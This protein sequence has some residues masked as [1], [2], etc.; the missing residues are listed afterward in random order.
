M[1]ISIRPIT[2]DEVPGFRTVISQA[3]GGDATEGGDERFLQQVDLGRTYVA[4]DGD[5]MV[6]TSAA[7]TF[8][9]TVPG[10]MA[11]MGGLTMVAVRPTHRRQGVLRRLMDAHFADVAARDEP[12]SGLWASETAIYGR[13]GY[14]DAVPRHH[15]TIDVK[16]TALDSALATDGVRLIG[17]DE[18]RSTLPGL[19]ETYRLGRVGALSRSDDWWSARRF[20]DGPEYREG[21]SKRRYAIAE[22]DGAPVGYVMYRQKEKWDDGWLPDGEV[23]VIEIIGD[24]RATASLW[25]FLASIDLFPRLD[26]WNAPVDDPVK[27]AASNRRAVRITLADSLWVRLMDVDRCLALRRYGA[28]GGI[29]MGVTDRHLPANSGAR[30]LVVDA[31]GAA[32]VT[33]TDGPPDVE[34][35]VATLGAL[36]LGGRS[37]IELAAAGLISGDEGHVRRL[38]ELM[39]WD[40]PW[41]PEVF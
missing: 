26:W 30:R 35:D 15:L 23:G 2:S 9:V 29:V 31:D 28:S 1:S 36:Y 13:F 27:W 4:F 32:E 38:D 7:F 10:G 8:D 41:C 40:P 18:A 37:A 22:R 11:P 33:D 14:G 20:Y 16:R 24:R 12:L 5:D 17:E 19:Y 3:F 6:A 39:R 25:A 34:L 21:A